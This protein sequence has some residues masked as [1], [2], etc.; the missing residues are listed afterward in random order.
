MS[1][2]NNK[3]NDLLKEIENQKNSE[4]INEFFR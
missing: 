4:E 1:F 2:V 3:D